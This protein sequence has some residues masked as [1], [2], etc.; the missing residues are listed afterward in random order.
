[1]DPAREHRPA[2]GERPRTRTDN[3]A[4]ARPALAGLNP[5]ALLALQRS[6]GNYRVARLLSRAP[7]PAA[8]AAAAAPAV[9]PVSVRDG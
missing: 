4:A 1:M 3:E 6:A 2:S 7:A 9:V 5:G 8:P